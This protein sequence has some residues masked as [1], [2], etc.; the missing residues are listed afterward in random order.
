MT[1]PGLAVPGFGDSLPFRIMLQ[2]V[3]DLLEKVIEA[4]KRHDFAAVFVELGQSRVAIGE[5]KASARGGFEQPP[6]DLGKATDGQARIDDYPGGIERLNHAVL[7]EDTSPGGPEVRISPPVD[8]EQMQVHAGTEHTPRDPDAVRVRGANHHHVVLLPY[9]E[10]PEAGCVRCIAGG[11]NVGRA[12]SGV[13][14]HP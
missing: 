3:L 1:F 5:L 4:G 8:P 13:V 14:V 2:V 10:S 12:M 7:G 11:K 9:A 6:F